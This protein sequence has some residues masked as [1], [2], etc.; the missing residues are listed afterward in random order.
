MRFDYGKCFPFGFAVR[1]VG[2]PPFQ[3]R[4]TRTL[5]IVFLA[6]LLVGSSAQGEARKHYSITWKTLNGG[7][8]YAVHQIA[9]MGQSHDDRRTCA[10]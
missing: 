6:S 8:R 5:A 3:A 1:T 2:I 10:C 9:G 7:G 4:V